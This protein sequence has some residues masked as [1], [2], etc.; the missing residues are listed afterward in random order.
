MEQYK[1][2]NDAI[3][4]A[5]ANLH[6]ALIARVENVNDITIDALPVINRVID[7]ESHQLPL[8]KDIPIIT[9]QGGGTYLSMPVKAGDYCLLL[10]NERCFDDWY[11]GGDFAPPLEKRM[12]DYSDAFAIVGINPLSS[13]ISIPT[14]MAFFD[15]DLKING[16]LTID[17]NLTIN[18]DADVSGKITADEVESSGDVV[19][20]GISLKTHT[21]L[22]PSGGGQTSAPS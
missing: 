7:G 4:D 21:H 6:T 1:A 13:A 19:A 8:F 18:G 3:N 15:G 5:L 2:I 9:L 20:G 12:H 10:I 16:D 22:A 17:G 11:H 14:D